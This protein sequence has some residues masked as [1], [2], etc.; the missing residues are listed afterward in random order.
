MMHI[1]LVLDNLLK[2]SGESLPFFKRSP[3][4]DTLVGNELN[5]ASLRREED[6]STDGRD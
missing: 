6:W 1:S 2:Q 5:I 4:S 3:L